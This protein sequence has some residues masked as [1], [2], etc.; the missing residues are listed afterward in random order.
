MKNM[1]RKSCELILVSV[2]ILGSNFK[3]FAVNTS[4][5]D[6]LKDGYERL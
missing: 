1:I 3:T 5:T 4:D 2:I 6:Y